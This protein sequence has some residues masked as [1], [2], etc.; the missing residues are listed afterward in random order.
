MMISSPITWF[1]LTLLTYSG[2]YVLN[3]KRARIWRSPV[4]T[5]PLLII[6]LL[7]FTHTDYSTYQSATESISFFLGPLQL[8]MVVPLYKYRTTLQRHFRF[9]MIGVFLGSCSGI[10]FTLWTTKLFHLGPLIMLSLTPKSATVPMAISISQQLGGV[11]ELT[12][13]FTVITGLIGLIIGPVLFH[14]FGITNSMAKG[15]AL[16]AAAQVAGAALASQ[17]GEL[18]GA[19][20]TL[21]M[22]LTALLITFFCTVAKLWGAFPA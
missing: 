3:M 5:C 11:P 7:F 20:G 16:G 14:W 1:I 15:L 21:G 12:A 19:L 4:F 10:L 2:V 13:V 8:A 9:V 22:V 18:E 17:W 6:L